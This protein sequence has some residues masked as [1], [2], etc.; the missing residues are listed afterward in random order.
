MHKPGRFTR[1]RL[2][3]QS[4]RLETAP[5]SVHHA[6]IDTP[7]VRAPSTLFIRLNVVAIPRE[8]IVT[9]Q[10][11]QRVSNNVYVA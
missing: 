11:V 2:F 9:D 8:V 1:L 3:P 5:I 4:F 7:S 10:S 6:L